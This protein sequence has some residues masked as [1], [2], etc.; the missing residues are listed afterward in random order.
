MLPAHTPH[1][2]Q[3][4]TRGPQSPSFY[5]DW[6]VT[7][8]TLRQSFNLASGLRCQY[9]KKSFLEY[10]GITPVW[11]PVIPN[12]KQE[13]QSRCLMQWGYYKG[14]TESSEIWKLFYDG[15][16]SCLLSL[17][18]FWYLSHDWQGECGSWPL[19]I[20]G[21]PQWPVAQLPI[22]GPVSGGQL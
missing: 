4:E 5:S 19:S 2:E 7:S 11:S 13:T 17:S 1:Y 15:W 6:H 16:Q 9:W 14:S 20:T 8:L 3:Q 21:H 18:L 12:F 10:T 22:P